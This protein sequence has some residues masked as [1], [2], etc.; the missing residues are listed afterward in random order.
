MAASHDSQSHYIKQRLS[1]DSA[2]CTVRYIGPVQGTKNDWLGVEWDDPGRGLSPSEVYSHTL[3]PSSGSADNLFHQLGKSKDATAASFVRPTRPADSQ[4]GFL[5]ALREKYASDIVLPIVGEESRIQWGGKLVEEV[6]FEKIRQQLAILNELRIV[7]LDGMRICGLTI[8]AGLRGSWEGE[9][10]RWR[11][12]V[13][14]VAKTCPAI[15]ELDLSRNLFEDWDQIIRI[16]LPLQRLR[17]LKVN[18]NQFNYLHCRHSD[19]ERLAA[20][21]GVKEVGLDDLLLNEKESITVLSLCGNGLK[22]LH[23]PLP[24]KTI[25]KLHLERNDI[26]SLAALA[27]LADLEHLDCL[28]LRDNAIRAVSIG[29]DPTMREKEDLVLP[30]VTYV[31]LAYNDIGSWGV[32]NALP[33]AFPALTGLRIAHNPLYDG[34]DGRPSMG[35]EEASVLT[36]GRLRNLKT[37]NFSSISLQE[38]TNAEL[39]YLSQIAHALGEVG[40]NQEG[41]IVAQHPR[42]QELCEEYGAPN[43]I[44][45]SATSLDPDSLEARL[46]EFTFCLPSPASSQII[47]KTKHIPRGFDMYRVKGLVGRLFS[48]EP[49]ELRLISETDEWD[50]VSGRPEDDIWDSGS[51]CDQDERPRSKENWIKREVELVDGTREV[52]FWVE[53][54]T[55]RVRIEVKS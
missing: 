8:D 27:P 32:I 41:Q 31:D 39:Y 36:I 22:R 54:R 10:E 50:P 47:T 23:M 21:A 24:A 46:I 3:P 51:E 29:V 17:S 4:T 15:E 30:T 18:G 26:T 19:A 13:E 9:E 33:K 37:L 5:Q 1:F 14:E 55:A 35:V 53:G 7:L 25:T 12:D 28:F 6:G 52:G 16:C 45:A 11:D 48:L 2:L 34:G 44:R 43:I 42:Y 20:F 49:S 40:E 38:R